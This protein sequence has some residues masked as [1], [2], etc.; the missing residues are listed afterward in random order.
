MCFSTVDSSANFDARLR[1]PS[2]SNTSGRGWNGSPLCPFHSHCPYANSRTSARPSWQFS[3]IYCRTTI[4]CGG[5]SLRARVPKEPTPIACWAQLATIVWVHY[6]S[7]HLRYNR[8]RL[9]LLMQ[10]PSLDARLES[11]LTI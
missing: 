11:F 10:C 5:R 4:V 9:A 1:G 3:R 8:L 6:S 7:F 2:S